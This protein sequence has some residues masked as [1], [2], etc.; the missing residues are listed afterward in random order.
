MS[1]LWA[2][3][4][5][6]PLV[7]VLIVALVVVVYKTTLN[8]KKN[9]SSTIPKVL[10]PQKEILSYSSSVIG[11]SVEGREIRV[12]SY[13]SGPTHLTFVGGIH[14][15][16]EW[17]TVLLAYTFMDYLTLH[18]ELVP[19]N[20]TIDIIPSANP[21]AVYMVTGKEGRFSKEDVSTNT[22]VLTSAR[23]N[24]NNVDLNRNFDCKWQPTSTWRSK[25]VSA[26]ASS[27]SEPESRALRD[28]ITK[29][30]P[31]AVVFWH[32]QAGGVYASKCTSDILPK[33]TI[34]MNTYAQASGYKAFTTFD[35]Y[36][37]TGAADDWLASVAIPSIT[38]ELKTHTTVEWEENF[39]AIKALIEYYKK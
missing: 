8:R 20:I 10:T 37:T 15:G 23:F 13:G 27:F 1:S 34:L 25:T 17:N 2:K 32:S 24:K 30:R 7:F 14:G 33:T 9:E 11:S 21:D 38:V 4:I 35:A 12:Y 19:E 39:A 16:Y 22:K 26:G 28:F 29:L 31:M 36:E 6:V 3:K 5:T 18:K